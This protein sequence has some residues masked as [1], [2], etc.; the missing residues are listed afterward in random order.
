[1][2]G[3]QRRVSIAARS[4]GRNITLRPLFGTSGSV[5]IQ[6]RRTLLTARDRRIDESRAGAF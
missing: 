4:G 6:T 1:M 2:A 3:A 5:V